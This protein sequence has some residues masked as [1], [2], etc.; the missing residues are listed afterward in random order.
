MVDYTVRTA[1]NK[2]VEGMT[3]DG[4]LSVA[5]WMREKIIS[6]QAFMITKRFK[7][8]ASGDS[9]EIYL[10][11][12]TGSGKMVEIATIEIV[13]T[14]EC[15]I[16]VYSGNTIT[17]NGTSITPVNMKIGATTTSVVNTEYGGT[18]TTGDTIMEL[19][20]PGGSQI[21]AVGGQSEISG[22]IMLEEGQNIV[23]KVT[24]DST[25]AENISVKITW[26]EIT[27]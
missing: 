7:S 22:E 13:T 27:P 2:L 15:S 1:L 18:Y 21:R 12:P 5:N 4:K 14:G 25:S 6:E 24:N 9:I 8:V 20:S 26:A 16:D 23:V 10:E 19:V 11:N 17:T 3:I